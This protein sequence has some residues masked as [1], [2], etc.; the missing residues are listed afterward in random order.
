M[1]IQ[2]I[3]TQLGLSQGEFAEL[4]GTT[5]TSVSQW[6]TGK[7]KPSPMAVFAM[8]KMLKEKKYNKVDS[9]EKETMKIEDL[10]G[11]KH[12][13]E[14]RQALGL[15]I[16]GF[17]RVLGCSKGE[18]LSWICEG[19]PIPSHYRQ[20]IKFLLDKK[21]EGKLKKVSSPYKDMVAEGMENHEKL[22]EAM[23]K[24]SPQSSRKKF[25]GQNFLGEE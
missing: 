18:Y 25:T 3:R 8:E 23:K 14:A 6:E 4:I 12:P 10:T 1:N 2:R 7:A 9:W 13:E 24:K 19:R 22:I 16:A 21:N 11:H 5:Q 15:S 20:F 17:A